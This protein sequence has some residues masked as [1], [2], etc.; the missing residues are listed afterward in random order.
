MNDR[1]KRFFEEQLQPEDV[2]EYSRA[3]GIQYA[4]AA[5]LIQVAKSDS[6]Q[7]ELERAMINVLLQDTFDLTDE[8]L[9]EILEFA[10]EALSEP[11]SIDQFVEMVK[12]HFEYSDKVKL[13]EYLW[14]VAFADGR[15]DRYEEQ[16]IQKVSDYIQV[17]VDDFNQAKSAAEER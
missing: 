14:V 17:S 8:M 9:E 2:D 16:F 11:D 12:D 4:T 13:V 10:D 6:E 5:L 15:L 1:L 3:V 7:D